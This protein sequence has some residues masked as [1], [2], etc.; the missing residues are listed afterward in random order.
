MEEMV[1]SQ[2]EDESM[3]DAFTKQDELKI[4]VSGV[5]SDRLD[6]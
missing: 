2:K 5:G 6:G 3:L 1:G 4:K